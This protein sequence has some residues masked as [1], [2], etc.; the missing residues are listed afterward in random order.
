MAEW[1]TVR[2]LGLTALFGGLALSA[3]VCADDVLTLY[4]NERPPFN[5]TDPSGKVSGL[6]A[7]PAV[8]A[9][10]RAGIPFR[11]EATPLARQFALIERGD[12]Y[13]CAVGLY[14]N[15][16]RELVGKLSAP[17][18]RDRGMV[19]IARAGLGLQ[20][21]ASFAELLRNRRLRMLYK[22]GLT[23]G[24]SV[25]R[26]IQQ[27]PPVVEMVSVETPVMVQMIRAE[28]A[29]WML[30]A[31]EEADYLIAQAGVPPASVTVV[32]F[33][34]LPGGETRHLFC[35]RAVPDALL[36]RINAALADAARATTG[37]RP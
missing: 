9:L 12:T 4:F 14:R 32:H 23:Y 25:S 10:R 20:D 24:S 37:E 19:A 33:R 36:E 11:W 1:M 34:D 2:S 13:A 26:L 22:T 31:E 21:G 17:L 3:D 7:T 15:P 30:A 8:A 28:R 18:Y 5:S 29:D 35:T 16:Q 6:T 27:T